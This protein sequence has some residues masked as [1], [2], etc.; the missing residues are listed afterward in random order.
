MRRDNI[1]LRLY[2][3]DLT[4]VPYNS[5]DV[6][7]LQ[8]KN[9]LSGSKEIIGGKIN[10]NP[11]YTTPADPERFLDPKYFDTEDVGEGY[12]TVKWKANFYED[13]ETIWRTVNVSFEG[14][15]R[16]GQP[17][18]HL[19][20]PS[21]TPSKLGYKF[22]D[23]YTDT[24]FK[25]PYVFI[26]EFRNGTDIY[27]LFDDSCYVLFEANGGKPIPETQKL[28]YGEFAKEP[29]GAS[30]PI[31]PGYTFDGWYSD[32]KFTYR[33]GFNQ[34]VTEDISLYAKWSPSKITVTFDPNGG[35]TPSSVT[36]EVFMGSIYGELPSTSQYGYTFDGWFTNLEGGV[37]IISS[38]VVENYYDH[39]L[40]AHWT[41]ESGESVEIAD[42]G[43]VI[44]THYSVS[45]DQY[46]RT[47]LEGRTIT[48][49][50]DGSSESS[51]STSYV[52]DV[53]TGKR[54]TTSIRTEYMDSHGNVVSVADTHEVET[55]LINYSSRTSETTV[56]DSSGNLI[57]RISEYSV[58][59][60]TDNVTQVKGTKTTTSGDIVTV[61]NYQIDTI[62][63]IGSVEVTN[64]STETVTKF[65]STST[66]T[67]STTAVTNYTSV[68][69][70]VTITIKE[71]Y[72][73]PSGVTTSR[74]ATSYLTTV[75]DV[76]G[77]RITS[78]SNERYRD[79]ERALL[80]TENKSCVI[81]VTDSA[82]ER[83]ETITT[84]Y[85]DKSSMTQKSFLST[86]YGINQASVVA[87]STE[88]EVPEH[89]ASVT[90]RYI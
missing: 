74:E 66:T 63:R 70:N 13:A 82:R 55:T 67:T 62:N 42:D 30:K 39:T 52:E 76:N 25:T 14:V 59:T 56:R 38:T 57:S 64:T 33:Y 77:T 90:L 81:T 45:K 10:V 80:R 58:Q 86:R 23:W 32:E 84:I 79:S 73:T 28:R 75:N 2:N 21:D 60:G 5:S 1:T 8:D 43:S 34:P 85:A 71:T 31:R 15:D 16:F 72:R 12:S 11:I 54:T 65:G 9:I 6:N 29:S 83:T 35:F 27:A 41:P 40:Y 47:V 78:E 89:V 46:G 48:E 68:G 36:K 19:Q 17:Y 22:V 51:V 4:F 20:K 37:K 7:I 49:N 44:K 26:Q 87:T 53:E 50:I 61:L 3:C 24:T 69:K 18:G 88:G